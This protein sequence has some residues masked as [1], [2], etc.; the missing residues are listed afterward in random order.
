MAMTHNPKNAE[1]GVSRNETLYRR[2]AARFRQIEAALR[3]AGLD[4]QTAFEVAAIQT[5][6]VFAQERGLGVRPGQEDAKHYIFDPRSGQ[7]PL[8]IDNVAD[9]AASI[10]FGENMPLREG[11][12]LS[13]ALEASTSATPRREG[14]VSRRGKIA[15]RWSDDGKPS[16]IIDSSGKFWTGREPDFPEHLAGPLY[17]ATSHP[18][19]RTRRDR[20]KDMATIDQ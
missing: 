8:S 19:Q 1:D 15:I 2:F 11:M 10:L 3:A 14:R 12:A 18:R 6:V 13:R 7:V 4:E 20:G 9:I 17:V 5:T 16:G